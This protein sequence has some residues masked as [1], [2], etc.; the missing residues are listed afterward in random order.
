MFL[1]RKVCLWFREV[2]VLGAGVVVVQVQVL[3]LLAGVGAVVVLQLHRL[4]PLCWL[5]NPT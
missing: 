5:E 4:A 3:L 1:Y 2:V